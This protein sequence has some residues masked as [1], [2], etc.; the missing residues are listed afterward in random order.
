MAVRLN[1]S[2][3]LGEQSEWDPK[4]SKLAQTLVSFNWS[5]VAEDLAETRRCSWATVEAWIVELCRYLLLK[6]R[7]LFPVIALP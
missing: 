6:V 1:A 2:M 5:K 4:I 3:V 7:A